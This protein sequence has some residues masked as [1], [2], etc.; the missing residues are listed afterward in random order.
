M[1]I[2]E[3][4]TVSW[5]A[6]AAAYR[7]QNLDCLKAIYEK[8][9]TPS[10][11]F[12]LNISPDIAYKRILERPNQDIAVVKTGKQHLERYHEGFLTALES[13]H[14]PTIILDSENHSPIELLAQ[15]EPHLKQSCIERMLS[16]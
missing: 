14:Y 9:L 8:C 13:L 2:A 3:P 16:Q 4:Y 12:F 15:I 7:V 5:L 10:L 11:S 6:T 1:F